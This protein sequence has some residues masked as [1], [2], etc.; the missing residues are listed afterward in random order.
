MFFFTLEYYTHTVTTLNGQVQLKEVANRCS[1]LHSSL[2][3]LLWELLD[4]LG[5]RSRII[6]ECL[7]FQ[8]EK[9]EK[10]AAARYGRGKLYQIL[11]AQSAV[12]DLKVPEDLAAA[13]P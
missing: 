8:S 9:L 13:V 3:V 6:R 11:R 1:C 5:T 4:L 12:L 2:W 7:D 10:P